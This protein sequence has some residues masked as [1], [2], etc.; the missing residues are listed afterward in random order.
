M[1]QLVF[2][3]QRMWLSHHD[4]DVPEQRDRCAVVG[5]HHVCRR[6]LVMYPI[7]LAVMAVA[8]VVSLPTW[9]MFVLPIPVAVE[10]VGEAA[11]TWS[12][13][14]R[15]QMALTAIAAPALGLG[16]ARAVDNVGDRA[17]WTMVGVFAVPCVLAA[18]VKGWSDHRKAQAL[19]KAADE[20]HPLLQGFNSAAEFRSYLDA[21]NETT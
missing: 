8:L 3:A 10:F 15:R 2:D 18:L 21:A 6:C 16:F 14:P 7:A 20:N 11:G 5:G 13:H 1:H 12:Y 17:L 4:V 9:I 19:A